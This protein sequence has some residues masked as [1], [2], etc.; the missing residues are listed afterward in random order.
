LI[1][2]YSK[3]EIVKIDED[4]EEKVKMYDLKNKVDPK[5]VTVEYM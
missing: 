2:N 3:K 5:K 4:G 1:D